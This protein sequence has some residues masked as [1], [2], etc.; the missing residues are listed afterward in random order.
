MLTP[1]CT[2]N[3]TNHEARSSAFHREERRGWNCAGA[4]VVNMIADS[5]ATEKP[6]RCTYPGAHRRVH[7]MV[8]AGMRRRYARVASARDNVWRWCRRNTGTDRIDVCELRWGFTT[9]TPSADGLT[10]SGGCT[11]Q[12]HKKA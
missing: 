12:V 10:G 5:R 7:D 2:R 9:P 4:R 3:E 11:G 8:S 1:E 6:D